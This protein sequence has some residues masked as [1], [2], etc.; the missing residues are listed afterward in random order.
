MTDDMMTLLDL[1]KLRSRSLECSVAKRE[2]GIGSGSS[3]G[4]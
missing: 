3:D 1:S 4:A 2:F